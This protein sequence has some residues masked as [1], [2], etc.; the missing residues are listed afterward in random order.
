MANTWYRIIH[1]QAYD[2][3]GHE[4]LVR[5]GIDDCS[6]DGLLVELSCDPTVD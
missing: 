1:G 2:S 4:S 6:D 3:N 5:H